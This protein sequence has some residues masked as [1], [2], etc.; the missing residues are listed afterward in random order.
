MSN[1]FKQDEFAKKLE[2]PEEARQLGPPSGPSI[3]KNS[4][5]KQ[6]KPSHERSSDYNQKEY[7]NSF[8][9]STKEVVG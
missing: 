9:F 6:Y 7:H 5:E 2:P 3:L 8:V 4:S 1:L